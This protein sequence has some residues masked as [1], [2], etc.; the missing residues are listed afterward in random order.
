MPVAFPNPNKIRTEST[1]QVNTPIALWP[2][3]DNSLLWILWIPTREMPS[4]SKC[5]SIVSNDASVSQK[6]SPRSTMIM[7]MMHRSNWD[8]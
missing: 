3:K 5:Y 1:I 4:P 7:T 6:Q 2:V 8:G